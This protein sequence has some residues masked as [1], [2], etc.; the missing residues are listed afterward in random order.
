[1]SAKTIEE[2]KREGILKS[3]SDPSLVVD[4]VL[5]GIPALDNILGGGIPLGRGIM[6]YGPEST[7]K[8]LLC[9]Y[10]VAAIQK[11]ERP[12]ALLFDLERCYDERWWKQSGVDTDKLIVSSPQT[13]EQV[14]DIMVQMIESEDQLGIIVVD[15]IPAMIPAPIADPDRSAEDKTMGLLPQ[16]VNLMYY[17]TM[18]QVALK[19]ICFV[20][21]NQ[22]RAN[23]SGFDE[24]AALPGGKAQRHFNQVI[25][26]THREGWINDSSGKHI[27]Y[28][29]K[30]IS[31][32][33]KTCSVPDGTDVTVPFL[34][35]GQIDMMTT[36]IDE[37]IRL[38]L[39][40]KRGPYYKFNDKSY[41]GMAG[42]RAF[43]VENPEELETL[44]SN[45]V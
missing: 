15:S 34:A 1:M 27:G 43:F 18:H 12:I 8:T 35:V 38:K 22:M 39:V 28:N 37:A 36:Y 24:V 29:M 33:N 4:R 16:I 45:S 9:Q 32:K 23:F 31:K 14:I 20:D 7:G 11:T 6:P 25:L 3:G 5:T 44:K 26:R 42:L 40:E 30:I 19:K 17:K 2:L 10:F 21:T 41:L 13:A